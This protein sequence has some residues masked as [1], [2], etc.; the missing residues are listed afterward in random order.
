[1]TIF[2]LFS[3][4]LNKRPIRPIPQR[5][6]T[7]N[8]S[9]HNKGEKFFNIIPTDDTCPLLSSGSSFL[10]TSSRLEKNNEDIPAK[11]IRPE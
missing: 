8:A 4:L 9:S 10:K 5:K 1:L 2:Q 6:R 11:N 3:G 7:G